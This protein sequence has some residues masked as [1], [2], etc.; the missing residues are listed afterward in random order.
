MQKPKSP[1]VFTNARSNL[2]FNCV[3]VL[4]VGHLKSIKRSENKGVQGVIYLLKLIFPV[5]VFWYILFKLPIGI[6]LNWMRR[7]DIQVENG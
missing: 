4:I 3:V 1:K 2:G 7:N 6:G 5:L